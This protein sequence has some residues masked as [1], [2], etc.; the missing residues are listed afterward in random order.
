M[1]DEKGGD[2][3]VKTIVSAGSFL[4]SLRYTE[5]LC[6][7]GHRSNEKSA[8]TR[9]TIVKRRN[10]ALGT[11]IVGMAVRVEFCGARIGKKDPTVTL[12]VELCQDTG[13]VRSFNAGG[14]YRES[15]RESNTKERKRK[16]ADEMDWSRIEVGEL[17]SAKVKRLFV[18][19]D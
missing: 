7:F 8:R 3:V 18:L 2:G 19:Y 5:Y 12:R 9:Q 17:R 16:R 6:I 11:F 15:T 4:V 1:D 10:S 13:M 14:E